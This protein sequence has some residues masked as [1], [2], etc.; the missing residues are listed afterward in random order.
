MV[1]PGCAQPSDPAAGDATLPIAA[2]SN[3]GQCGGQNR[4]AVRWIASSGEW[5]DLYARVNSQWMNPPPPPPV[6]FSRE[7]VLLIA[8]GQRSTAGFGLA[9]ADDTATVRD[10]VLTVRV[11]WRESL[12]GYRQAQVMTHPCLLAKLPDARFSR[13]QVVDQEGRLRLEGER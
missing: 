13:I 3:Q 5:R 1:L 11:N 7:G 10:G 6:D 2:L 9:L 4:P 8:M 12:P